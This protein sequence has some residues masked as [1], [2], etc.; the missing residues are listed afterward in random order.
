MRQSQIVKI[1]PKI[2]KVFSPGTGLSMDSINN[3][4]IEKLD[5]FVSQNNFLGTFL[6][7]VSKPLKI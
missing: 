4:Y 3:Y 2:F 5:N 1:S 6:K 7:V